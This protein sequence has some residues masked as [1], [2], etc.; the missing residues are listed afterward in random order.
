MLLV[1]AI[2]VLPFILS[3]R[4]VRAAA[5]SESILAVAGMAAVTLIL[6]QFGRLA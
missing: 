3:S 6:F 4:Y 2:V 1:A 5:P